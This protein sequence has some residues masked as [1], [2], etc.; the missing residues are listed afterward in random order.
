MPR[1]TLPQI[2][3]S[4]ILAAIL[5]AASPAF[6]EDDTPPETGKPLVVTASRI[7]AQV[8]DVPYTA[9][10]ITAEYIASRKASHSLG[11][12]LQEDPSIMVQ[13]T[14]NNQ[15]SPF[16]RGFTGFRTLFMI[17]GI[18][19]NN[20][21]FRDGPNQYWNTV[22][23][24]TIDRLEVVKGP[25]SVAYGSDAIGGTVNAVTRSRELTGEGWSFS[26]RLYGRYGSADSSFVGRAEL[27]GNQGE[28]FGFLAGISGKDF[29]D[30]HAG[31]DVGSQPATGYW[32]ADGD[33]KLEYRFSPERR[34]VFSYQ[35][36]SQL[37]GQRAHKTVNGV[38]WRGTTNGNEKKRELDQYRDL[39]YL[40]YHIDDL[41]EFPGKAALSL[42]YHLQQE[43][44][45]RIKAN[46]ES[47]KQ[48]FDCGTIGLSAAFESLQPIGRLSYGVEY[49]HDRVSSYLT[50]F[51]ADGSLK[52]VGVQGPVADDATYDLL[53]VFLQ[54][55][56]PITDR[57]LTTI[58]VRYTYA[59]ADADT[60]DIPA[61]SVS[62]HW[63][64]VVGSLRLQY[65]LHEA[66]S[67][68]GGVSQGFRAPNL[69]DLTRFDTARKDEA[70]VPSP[71]L[72][73]EEYVS[74]EIGL[75]AN[76]P[77]LRG[78]LAYF[79]TDINDMIIRYPNGNVNADGDFEVE[80]ANVG[81]GFVHGV[82]LNGELDLT[83]VL[84]LFGGAAWQEGEVDTYP[85]AA[86]VKTREPI[87]RMQPL[88]GLLG[89]RWKHPSGRYWAEATSQFADKQ[90]RLSTSDA[91]D[92]DRIPP[93]GTP[94]YAVY[95][96]RAGFKASKTVTLTAAVENIFD[97]AYR[98]HGSAQNEPGT[99]VV[100]A[101]DCR[102]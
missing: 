70:E 36:V 27:E 57:F 74:Y 97:E 26:Q 75:K 19:L 80:K 39:I 47:D 73:P 33:L 61:G 85:T 24:L 37:D 64:N 96:V 91:G 6:A 90:D 40:Q 60:V 66:W 35:H 43:D 7:Q 65:Y 3:S 4:T 77:G 9:D 23:P 72:S 41:G 14:S 8:F 17:D 84:T 79:Y 62:D 44:Q 52:E 48:G 76:C 38:N 13:K 89:L 55:E 95:G 50:K 10:V 98:I 22:D 56:V 34:L 5:A 82:E 46:D 71:G 67:I 87:S 81:D 30:V 94:G 31:G 92:T 1:R 49:Y 99:N 28:A 101:L 18:R 45:F 53:G 63:D 16:L 69:S 86:M 42:S 32:E 12:I 20:S 29:N 93:G 51:N 88:T 54:D 15:N 25:A 21:V 78:Q 100:L 58:G 102:F 2:L 68:F 83:R 11:A 59:R